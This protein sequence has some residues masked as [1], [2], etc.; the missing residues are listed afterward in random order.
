MSQKKLNSAMPDALPPTILF[1]SIGPNVERWQRIIGVKSDGVFGKSTKGATMEWQAAHG[2][3]ADGVVGPKTWACALGLETPSEPAGFP[4]VQA[5][6]YT[7]GPRKNGIDLIVIHD[8][9]AE[10]PGTAEQ[11][12]RWFAG[13]KRAASERPLLR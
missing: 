8:G 4:F 9:G 2:L 3:Y 12:A 6:Y 13:P 11:V 7:K 10:K 1:A 5:K